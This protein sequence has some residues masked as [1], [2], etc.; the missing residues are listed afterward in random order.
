MRG[1]WKGTRAR[2]S[3]ENKEHRG[4]EKGRSCR[5]KE[6]ME[7]CGVTSGSVT[8][9]WA[10]RAIKGARKTKLR[11]KP[12]EIPAIFYFPFF[13][14]LYGLSSFLSLSLSDFS[15]CTQSCSLVPRF[16]TQ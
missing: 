6:K 11:Y 14:L 16:Y 1:W 10:R 8:F 7:R 13:P 5:R 3:S 4:K 15:T 2:S 12:R 9:Q